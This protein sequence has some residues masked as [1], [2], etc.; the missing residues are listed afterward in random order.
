MMG[1]YYFLDECKELKTL[2]AENPDLPFIFYSE[3][4]RIYYPDSAVFSN[5]VRAHKGKILDCPNEVDTETIFDD[6]RYFEER[7]RE[8]LCGKYAYSNLSEEEF[9]KI[10]KEEKSIYDDKWKDCIIVYVGN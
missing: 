5:C 3:I 10:F 9:E 6:K 4:D 2:I 1:E 8:M 7:L